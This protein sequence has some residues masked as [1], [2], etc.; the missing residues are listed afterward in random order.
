MQRYALILLSAL[1]CVGCVHTRHKSEVEVEFFTSSAVPVLKTVE[2]SGDFALYYD[3]DRKP[4][5]P[6]RC[7]TDLR[8]PSAERFLSCATTPRNLS[9]VFMTKF[10]T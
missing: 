3:A 2:R 5:I 8:R 10:C 4:E 6:V 7:A 1:M 9:Y